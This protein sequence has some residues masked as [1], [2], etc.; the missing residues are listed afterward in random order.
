[1]K[2]R[3]EKMGIAHALI[4]RLNTQRLPFLLE[5]EKRVQA[6]ERLSDYELE[7]LQE[8]LGDVQSNERLVAE[9]V[10]EF[11]G[12]QGLVS[13]VVDLYQSITSKALENEEKGQSA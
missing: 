9:L 4:H 7:R 1:M 8:A 3:D 6:G 5:V 12:L 10:E 2:T 11:P 13:R